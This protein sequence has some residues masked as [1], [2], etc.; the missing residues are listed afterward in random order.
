MD[1]IAEILYYY[2]K[3]Q[4][5]ADANFINYCFN[6]IVKEFDVYDY[7]QQLEIGNYKSNFISR[8]LPRKKTLYINYQKLLYLLSSDIINSN[9]ISGYQKRLY[10]LNLM[11]LKVLFHEIEHANQEKKK[12][13][14][15]DE[16][17]KN[18]LFLSDKCDFF[19]KNN[20]IILYRTKLYYVSPIERGAEL[21]ALENIMKLCGLYN[22]YQVCNYFEKYYYQTCN[23]GYEKKDNM[24]V[25]PLDTYTSKCDIIWEGQ[26]L[27][28]L[29]FEG[30]SLD[31]KKLYGLKLNQE[32][33]NE[34]HYVKKYRRE[35][36]SIY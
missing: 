21:T 28:N 29:N 26:Q 11:V 10:T 25:C 36:E 4:E 17:E 24:I 6:E 9:S 5:I 8:Y 7:M 34:M 1:N 18:I 19:F 20:N 31:F 35:N 27:R 30:C 13:D 16:I 22:G 15:T 23:Y 2:L 32:E 33:Y 3:Q 12:H 14:V